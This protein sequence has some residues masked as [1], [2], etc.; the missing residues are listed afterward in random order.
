MNRS[1][2]SFDY[3]AL[4]INEDS[5]HKSELNTTC[6]PNEG[7][8]KQSLETC[9]SCL[10]PSLAVIPAPKRNMKYYPF[11]STLILRM[12]EGKISNI[13]VIWL[14][15][16]DL[17]PILFRSERIKRNFYTQFSCEVFLISFCIIRT[18][19][20][21]FH[22]LR[23]NRR[24]ENIDTDRALTTCGKGILANQFQLCNI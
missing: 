23:I 3:T 12:H 16:K 20:L 6:Y 15:V 13:A 22:C 1:W 10:L 21:K 14:Y 18:S 17:L 11:K 19:T 2:E 9:N 7:P 4:V 24:T 5:G 8:D